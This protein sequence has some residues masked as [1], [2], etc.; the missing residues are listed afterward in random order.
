METLSVKCA[1][2]LTL[3]QGHWKCYK[4]FK[5]ISCLGLSLLA[6]LLSMFIDCKEYVEDSKAEWKSRW[7]CNQKAEIIFLTF[8]RV[9]WR[10]LN[11]LVNS[12]Y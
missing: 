5:R 12:F 1:L 11:I 4:P 8:Q 6:W 2:S 7:I 10:L 9:R 3:L